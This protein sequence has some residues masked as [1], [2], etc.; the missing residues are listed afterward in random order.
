MEIDDAEVS[1]YGILDF[2]STNNSVIGLVEK[3][4]LPVAPSRKASIGRYVLSPEIFDILEKIPA[5]PGGEIQLS[6]AIGKLAVF[7]GVEAIELKG[8]RF[9]C[10]SVEGFMAASNYEYELRYSK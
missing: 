6:T 8:K 5:D 10:G 9:D 2:D 3:P 4:S 1:K 7:S